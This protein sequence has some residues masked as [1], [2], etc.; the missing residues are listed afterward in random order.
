MYA[1]LDFC[2]HKYKV[3]TSEKCKFPKE[4]KKKIMQKIKTAIDHDSA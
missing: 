3:K 1:S 2:K 4:L